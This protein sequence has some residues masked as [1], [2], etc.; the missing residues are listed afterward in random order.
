MAA[1]PVPAIYQAILAV[2]GDIGAEGITKARRNEQQRYNFRGIDDIYNALN[3]LFTKHGLFV[4]SRMLSRTV[5]ERASRSGGA[6]FYATVEAEFDFTAGADGSKVTARMFGEAMDAAD[7]ATNKAQSAAYKYAIMQTFCIPTE[8]DNDADAT[9]HEPL[10][11]EP[12]RD[13]EREPPRPPQRP[14]QRPPPAQAPAEPE[15]GEAELLAA[16]DE[17]IRRFAEGTEVA[18]YEAISHIT[19]NDERLYLWGYLKNHAALRKVIKDFW[20]A[21]ATPVGARS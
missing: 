18:A 15:H 21:D 12:K 11:R 16:A 20:A 4:V 13:V 7:K 5:E 10:P 8:G 3:P 1:T 2:Q 9:T 17:A 14:P 19:D 6:L